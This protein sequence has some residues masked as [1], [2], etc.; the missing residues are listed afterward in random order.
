MIMAT[1]GNSEPVQCAARLVKDVNNG[2]VVEKWVN[3]LL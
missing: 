3:M 2:V 1:G